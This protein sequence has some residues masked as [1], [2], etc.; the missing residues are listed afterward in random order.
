MKQLKVGVIG[1]SERGRTLASL[2]AEQDNVILSAICDSNP[3]HLELT[4]K[5]LEEKGFREIQYFEKA[6]EL[7]QTDVD[8]VCI[9][10]YGVYHVPLVVESMEAGKHVLSEIPAINSLQE[11]KMLKAITQKHPNLKYMAAENCCYWAFVQAWK[12]MYENGK[13]GQIVYAESEYLH[14]KDFREFKKDDYPEDHWRRYNPAI[15]YIT[16]NLGPLLYIMEDKCVSVTCLESDLVY[17]PYKRGSQ[18]GVALIKTKKGAMIRILICFGAYV[19]FDHNFRLLGTKGTIETDMV[20]SLYDA[21][22]WARFSDI[23]GSIDDKVDI[24]VS[25]KF[26]GESNISGHGGAD[27]K[28]IAAFV[29]CIL[30]DTKSPID[31]DFAIQMS[32]PGILAHESAEKGGITIEIPDIN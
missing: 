2:F 12:T 8:A 23:P 4:K 22:S 25:V 19:G 3:E 28:M 31:V 27:S 1:V 17:N 11:A 21:H 15:K 14:A 24:P 5:T 26:P 32:L 10:T 7:L 20:K 30:E 29:K 18:T 16:H 9:A 6:E 13:F